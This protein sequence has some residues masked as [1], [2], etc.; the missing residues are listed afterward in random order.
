MSEAMPAGTPATAAVPASAAAPTGA[1]I[2][3]KTWNNVNQP[4]SY[5]C[6]DTGLLLRVPATGLKDGVAPVIDFLGPQ[7]PVKVTRISDNPSLPIADLRTLSISA[8]I[9]PQF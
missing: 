1:P 6:N 3:T 8:Q 2:A 5:V 7:G 4:G 9:K